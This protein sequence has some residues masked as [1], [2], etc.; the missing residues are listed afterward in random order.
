MPTL[1]KYDKGIKFLKKPEN[2][3]LIADPTTVKAAQTCDAALITHAHTDHSL[4]FPNE[5]IKVF[6]TKLSSQLFEGLTSRKTRNTDFIELNKSTNVNDIEVKFIPAGHLLGAA[7]IV[8]YFDDLT[9]CYTGD[10]STD[11]MITVPR[12]AI[13]EDD[14]DILIT[15]ATYGK[16]DLFFDSRERIKSSILKWIAENLQKNKV[17]VINIGHLGPTQEIIAFLNEM[18]SVDIYCDNRTSEINKIYNT[19]GHNL[20]WNRFDIL[21]DNELKTESSVVLLS[22]AA[23]ELPEFLKHYDVARGMITGQASRF[24]YSSFE[25]AFPFSMHANCNELLE[26]IKAINPQKVYTVYGFDSEFASII[27]QKLRIPAQPIKFTKKRLT[28]EEFL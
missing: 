19:E 15:E 27:R 12:A 28:L 25:Q 14:V 2:Q 4:A 26:H 13:P 20:Q 22:R 5:G 1:F 8:F 3:T 24:A 18:L 17:P 9:I 21:N 7:Q 10:I 23:K 11:K 6:S 16:G